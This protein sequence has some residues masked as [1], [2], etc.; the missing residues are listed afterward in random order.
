MEKSQSSFLETNQTRLQVKETNLPINELLEKSIKP[1][2]SKLALHPLPPAV[3]P[4]HSDL[5]LIP[6]HHSPHN[7]SKKGPKSDRLVEHNSEKTRVENTGPVSKMPVTGSTTGTSNRTVLKSNQDSQSNGSPP[8]QS[9]PEGHL[10]S[11]SRGPAQTQPQA[12]PPQSASPVRRDHTVRRL[13]PEENRPRKS[14]LYQPA[15]SASARNH[16]R[17]PVVFNRHSSSLLHQ[18]DLLRRGNGGFFVPWLLI[19]L[20][21]VIRKKACKSSG[22][23]M[24]IWNLNNYC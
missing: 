13:D 18:Y 24:I 9:E 19:F 16:S 15:I 21:V 5:D 7:K 4:K 22:K 23:Y 2:D 3:W 1:S 10:N 6:R 14:S 11:R 17:P 20:V 8:Q 12:Q